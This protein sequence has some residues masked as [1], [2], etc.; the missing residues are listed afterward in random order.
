[1]FAFSVFPAA[2]R[3]VCVQ[4]LQLCASGLKSVLSCACPLTLKLSLALAMP[5][6]I[7]LC[8][9]AMHALDL[10][11]LLSCLALFSPDMISSPRDKERYPAGCEI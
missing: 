3:S 6:F 1:M 11:R 10:V 4:D 8:I 9:F 2:C 7:F 5:L